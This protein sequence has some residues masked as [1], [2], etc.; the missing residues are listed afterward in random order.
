MMPS[1]VKR[2]TDYSS[3]PVIAGGLLTQEADIKNALEAG[4]VGVSSTNPAL[5]GV[6]FPAS[7]A[8][9]ESLENG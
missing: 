4:A 1:I 5:W 2:L 8:G 6:E 9:N 7:G 3:I